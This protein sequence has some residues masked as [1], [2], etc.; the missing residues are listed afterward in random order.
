MLSINNFTII[1]WLII[2]IILFYVL[3]F[4]IKWRKVM[5]FLLSPLAQRMPLYIAPNHISL[6]GFLVLLLVAYFIYLAKFNYFFF[7]WAILLILLYCILDSLDGLLARTR[8]QS[9]KSGVFLDQTLGQVN[10]LL[11]LLALLLGAHVRAELV[12]ISMIGGVFYSFISIQSEVLIGSRLPEND[13]PRWLVL[14]IILL[15]TTFLTKLFGLEDFSLLEQKI[16]VLDAIFVIVPVYYTAIA[17]YRTGYLWRKIR[18]I[19][20]G[21]RST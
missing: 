20:K 17:L 5:V 6:T 7:L 13:R 8:N 9:T 4:R 16:R 21:E 18:E 12:V 11:L 14:A 1:I 3:A 2:I 10:E 19:E 15:M